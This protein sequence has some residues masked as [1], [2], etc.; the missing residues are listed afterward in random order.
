MVLEGFGCSGDLFKGP[1]GALELKWSLPTAKPRFTTF[2]GFGVPS[3][4]FF[5]FS[6]NFLLI[7]LFLRFL[8]V[9]VPNYGYFVLFWGVCPAHDVFGDSRK[10]LPKPI[11]SFHAFLLSI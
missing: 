4:G 5:T 9:L 2:W 11:E 1:S 8:R 7:V 10:P 3:V 6:L